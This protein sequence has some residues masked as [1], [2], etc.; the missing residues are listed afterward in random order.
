[1]KP[2]S[3]ADN[4]YTAGQ[5]A[6]AAPS[7]EID[8]ARVGLS[9][10]LM[11][12]PCHRKGFYSE[13]VRDARGARLR[14]PMPEKV[15]FGS[16]IDEAHAYI[17]WHIREDRPWTAW[18]AVE[19]GLARAARDAGSWALVEDR[20][21]FRR[22]VDNAITLFLSQPDGLARLE[23]EIAGIRAQ[24]NEGESLR[25]DDVIG[26]PDYLLADGSVLDVK[27]SHAKYGEWKF[28]RSP[29]MPV[30]AYLATAEAG[31]LPPRLIYQVYVR[32]QKPYWQWIEV[33]A[34][35]AHVL[36]GKVHA[37]HWRAAL[38]AGNPD[39]FAFDTTYC[40]DCPF[41]QPI[42]EV[43][44]AGCEVGLLIHEEAA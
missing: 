21:T 7:H 39:V 42:A 6:R 30:Y 31:V 35:P 25:A 44:F 23:P 4:P 18:E 2:C 12:T 20:D 22:Q 13:T 24:G 8:N 9:K 3:K 38:A 16:A 1:M 27:T 15:T 34:T 19:A 32:V 40:A 26:T 11:T 43:G 36:L 17:V 14:F 10:S 33:E 28:T 41:A 5:V 29:E 37:A